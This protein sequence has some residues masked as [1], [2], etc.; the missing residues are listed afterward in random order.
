MPYRSVK[1]C[2][3]DSVEPKPQRRATAASGSTVAV[4][5]CAAASVRARRTYWAGVS[6]T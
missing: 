4:S 5:R 3:S 6:C 1:A 2:R